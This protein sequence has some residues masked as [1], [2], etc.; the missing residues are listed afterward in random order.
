MEVLVLLTLALGLTSLAAAGRYI[1][2]TVYLV[3]VPAGTAALVFWVHQQLTT[4]QQQ[5]VTAAGAA[6]LDTLVVLALCA[7][8]GSLVLASRLPTTTQ[9]V[10]MTIAG[11]V[12]SSIPGLLAL[13][14]W[15]F[16]NFTGWQD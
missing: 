12:L 1:T 7:L 8:I 4:G 2:A 15:F 9:R 3:L 10:M 16:Q 6:L 13:V 5:P 11:F 14:V